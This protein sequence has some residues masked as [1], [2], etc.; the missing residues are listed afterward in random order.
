M[1]DYSVL[2]VRKLC[3]LHDRIYCEY[4]NTK[5]KKKKQQ[6]GVCVLKTFWINQ[7]KLGKAKCKFCLVDISCARRMLCL[8]TLWY[9]L[10]SESKL[11]LFGNMC[12]IAEKGTK[13]Y[14]FRSRIIEATQK[15][16]S[17]GKA[18]GIYCQRRKMARLSRKLTWFKKKNTEYN[19]FKLQSYSLCFL[20]WN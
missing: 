8:A 1:T 12:R 19:C 13:D 2:K 18:L 6:A 17:Q 4:Q 9:L 16:C 3:L 5:K 11:I 10:L 20:A 14:T 7:C 15:Q